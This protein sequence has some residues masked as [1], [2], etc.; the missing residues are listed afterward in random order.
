MFGNKDKWIL[1]LCGALLK[2]DVTI[3]GRLALGEIILLVLLPKTIKC[4]SSLKKEQYLSKIYKWLLIWFV[5]AI[6]SDIIN[7]NSFDFILKGAFRP[8]ICIVILI[9]CYALSY[10]RPKNL[11]YFFFGLLVSG[12][13]N[14]IHPLDIR[15]GDGGSNDGYQYY[16]Y[17]YTPFFYG[18]ASVGGYWLYKKSI[19]AASTLC[20]I[21]G[22]IALPIL[23][24]TTASALL[25]SGIILYVSNKTKLTRNW[26][27][28]E[29][30]IGKILLLLF[31]TYC[32]AFYPYV[33]FAKNGMMGERQK[34]KF[35]MQYNRS[36]LVQNPIGFLLS[37]RVET[38]GAMIRVAR[39]PIIGYGSWPPRGDSNVVAAKLVGIDESEISDK[40]FDFTYRDPGHSVFFGIWSQA[41][42]CVVPFFL[43][44]LSCILKLYGYIIS[45]GRRE[46]ILIM[47]YAFWFVFSFIFNNFNSQFRFELLIFPI[48]YLYYKTERLK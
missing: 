36:P 8:V 40:T 15:A 1:F 14:F 46:A 16:A 31:L 45:G 17:V 21:L 28:Q 10:K 20:V 2:F 38:V 12:F 35:E 18:L 41:G 4:L 22:I 26:K 25:L 44:C 42:I 48:M 27:A 32:M 5:G 37:G 34:E 13:I 39:S 6:V 11:L 23:S 43:I 3:G 24:R 19:L 47:P 9:S 33:Y 29:M 30:P 7:K